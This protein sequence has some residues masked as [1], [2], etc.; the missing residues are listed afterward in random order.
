VPNANEY[1]N[2]IHSYASH[3][4]WWRLPQITTVTFGL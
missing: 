3:L 2:V 1:I 4:K